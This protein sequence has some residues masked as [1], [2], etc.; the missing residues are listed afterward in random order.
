MR[1]CNDKIPDELV[2]DKILRTLPPRFDHVVVAIEESR[3]LDGMEIEELQHSLEAHEMRIN[4][5]RSNQEQ[6]LQARSKYR[7]KGKGSWKGNK[8]CSNQKHQDQGYNAGSEFFK[9]KKS[10]QSHK[11]N[12]SS[13]GNKEWKVDNRKVRCHNCQKLGH[14]A[15]DC[16]QGEGAKN[17]PKNQANLAQDE[18]SDSV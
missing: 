2:V 14:Y 10:D 6:T 12:D 1:S 7:G 13:N 15:R 11:K 5:R 16:W 18:G 17:K 8:P 3:N 4:E 9:G